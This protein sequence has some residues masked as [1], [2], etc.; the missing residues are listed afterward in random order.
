MPRQVI[1]MITP[2]QQGSQVPGIGGPL[3][4]HTES[5]NVGSHTASVDPSAPAPGSS[6][7]GGA[8]PLFVKHER[9]TNTID[10]VIVL[11]AVFDHRLP[12]E[13]D[14]RL[15]N[16]QGHDRPRLQRLFTPYRQ[17]LHA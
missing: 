8:K 6:T 1:R 4:I 16:G 12:L 10:I 17:P 14:F 11:G 7:P 3:F 13:A 9:Q 5:N 2:Q 15:V